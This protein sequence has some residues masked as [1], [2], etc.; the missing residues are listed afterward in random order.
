[1][2][3]KSVLFSRKFWSASF[4]VLLVILFFTDFSNKSSADVSETELAPQVVRYSENFDGVQAPQIPGGWSVAS[5]GAGVN[6]ATVTNFSDTAPNAIFA[7]DASTTGLSELTSPPIVVTGATTT[8]KF[9]QKYSMENTWDGGV[10]EMR[11]GNGQFQDILAAGGVF[12]SGGYTATLNTSPNPLAGRFAWSGAT[13]TGFL[14]TSVRLPANTFG[15]TVQ[16]RWRMGSNDSFGGLG[17]W[18][19]SVSLETIATGANTNSISIANSGTATPYPSDIQIAG[20]PGLVTGVTVN[21]ENF[22]HSFPDDV[23]I[24]LVAPNGRRIILMSDAGG[25]TAAN[26]LSLTFSDTAPAF[27]P[28]N[29]QIS[30][31]IYKPTNFDDTDT[32]PA[33]A[34]QGS[35][36]GSALGAFYGTNPNGTWSLYVVDDNGNNAGTIAGGWNL[37]IQSSVSAC[38]FSISPSAQAFSAAGGSG[39]FQINIPTGCSWTA[40]T[41]NSFITIDSPT[42]G[43]NAA[44]INLTVAANPGAARTGLINVTDGFNPRTFQVQQ[45][46]G[47]PT[48]LAQTNLNFTA[49]GGSG[50]VAVTAGASCSWQAVSSVNW[51][52]VTSAQQT[53]NGTATFNVLPNPMRNARTTS[54]TV[55]ARTL[56]INQAGISAAKFDFDG[57]GRSDIS[58]Y[59]NGIW[60]LQQSTN[61]FAAA[62]FGLAADKITPADFDGDGRADIAV[63]RD[64]IWYVLPSSNGQF[65]AVQF[66]LA[67]DVPVPADFD[68]DGRSELAVFRSGVWYTFNLANNQ[69]NVFQFGLAGDKP[70]GGDYD[71]DGKADFAVYRSGT[72]YLQRSALGFAALQF[73]LA[74][75]KPTPADFD[76]DGKTDLAIYRNGEWHILTN[77]QN[78]SITQFG[79]AADLPVAADYDGDGRADIAV[80]RDG[81]WYV[82]QSSNAQAFIFQ[83]GLS[84]DKPVPAAFTP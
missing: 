76:G 18:I 36:S 69:T 75:D 20:L 58:V 47:C 43:V 72:W 23:D 59:R 21:L 22:S 44:T 8:L 40:S 70:V 25:G 79:L 9:R 32:F 12:L 34:P 51:V 78:Y 37:D 1:M 38:V 60:Y 74:S 84:G 80:F 50:N 7:P 6:F 26:N 53:G 42:S 35:V 5:S 82:L 68:G 49:A 56:N 15:Q 17:W 81:T 66:G 83:F 16:F 39:S 63:Y 57:D 46:S 67:N 61:G 3:K 33:P 10:L 52:V 77:F 29:S 14:L 45:G 73:G 30:S 71:A 31:G 65:F 62:Q 11:I 19:D 64:G 13:D 41:M 24:L 54:V 2:P 28:D 55:G 27:L 4:T 48:S